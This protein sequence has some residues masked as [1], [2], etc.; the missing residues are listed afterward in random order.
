MGDMSASNFTVLY[1]ANVLYPAPLRDLL[2]RLATKGIFRAKW[3]EQI[4]DEWI[5]NVVKNRKDL[6]RES[7]ERTAALMDSA[8]P[9]SLVLGYEPLIHGLE[10]PDEDDRH[11][12]AS[13]IK[14]Q[15]EVIVTF[16]QKDF[17]KDYLE[18]FDIWTQHPDEFIGHVID[19]HPDVI[20]LA[21]K[22]Q[23]LNLNNPKVSIN[24]FIDT[25]LH[26]QLPT[27]ATFLSNH[28]ELLEL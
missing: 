22:E 2:I 16:N 17:P 8:V 10:L 1:D 3:T 12:L 7:L 26:Q 13:A 15:A 23:R 21:A 9:D 18:Q 11:V 25:L 19:L 6:S 5:R 14:G 27:T 4:H 24:E 28:R 20:I